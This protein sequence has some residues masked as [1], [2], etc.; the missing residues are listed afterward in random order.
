M[1]SEWSQVSNSLKF[2]VIGIEIK[3]GKF[4]IVFP[5]ASLLDL[6][7]LKARKMEFPQDRTL[8]LQNFQQMVTMLFVH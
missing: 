7:L 3:R 6:K 2:P 5:N 1:E 8:F 4:Y